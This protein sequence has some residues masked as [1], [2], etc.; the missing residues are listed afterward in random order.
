MS[1]D[2]TPNSQFPQIWHGTT[3]VPNTRCSGCPQSALA[4]HKSCVGFKGDTAH[5][6]SGSQRLSLRQLRKM[7]YDTFRKDRD[8]TWYYGSQE[9][10]LYNARDSF[11][12]ADS[13]SGTIVSASGNVITIE[14]GVDPRAIILF[15]S[16]RSAE[17]DIGLNFW[18]NGYG[19]FG[20]PQPGDGLEYGYPSI[21]QSKSKPT[22]K[23][24]LGVSGNQ[25]T[26]RID[27]NC[28]N[29]MTLV[30]D[31]IEDPIFTVRIWNDAGN[32]Q[33]WLFI[34]EPEYLRGEPKT[35][36]IQ[37]STL[38]VD[39][40]YQLSSKQVAHPHGFIP[41]I[42][43]VEGYNNA[44]HRWDVVDLGSR[45]FIR[46]FPDGAHDA[47]IS[48][49]TQKPSYAVNP[50]G[51]FSDLTLTYASFRVKYWEEADNDCELPCYAKCKHS[52]IDYTKSI[53]NYGAPDGVSVDANGVHRY[54]DKRRFFV[55][56]LHD[57]FDRISHY[58]EIVAGQDGIPDTVVY[59]KHSPSGI[60]NFPAN[61]KPC[62]QWLTCDQF[63]AAENDQGNDAPFRYA[64]HA[65]RFFR[66]LWGA[67]NT[68][69]I[70]FIPGIA[71]SWN[72]Q[73]Q[74][75][76]HAGLQWLAGIHL[77][78]PTGMHPRT[79]FV[80]V[81][82]WGTSVDTVTDD[83][84]NTRIRDKW[85]HNYDSITDA[86]TG[87]ITNPDGHFPA[88]VT[89]FKSSR[90]PVNPSG[91]V[92]HNEIERLGV[93][94][95]RDDGAI[96]HTRGLHAW[97]KLLPESQVI[98]PV[99]R[100]TLSGL[101][102]LSTSTFEKF[103]AALDLWGD[104]SFMAGA[105]IT[106]DPLRQDSKAIEG[107]GSRRIHSATISGNEVT[108]ELENEPHSWSYV[109]NDG[110]PFSSYDK[111]LTW[112]AGGASPF[113]PKDPQ[114]IDSYYESDKTIGSPDGGVQRGDSA[115]ISIE[116]FSDW[117]FVVTYA[118][119]FDGSE[120]P[121]WGDN[122]V[123]QHTY[124][125][126][127]YFKPDPANTLLDGTDT[128]PDGTV[129]YH[130]GE[131][132]APATGAFVALGATTFT[133]PGGTIRPASLSLNMFWHDSSTQRVYL[134][135]A[136]DGAT[137][138]IRYGVTGKTETYTQSY[139]VA[140]AP[141]E[142]TGLSYTDWTDAD[143]TAVTYAANGVP[144][145]SYTASNNSG[146]LALQLDGNDAGKRINVRVEKAGTADT[147]S[148][149]TLS[150]SGYPDYA[151]K[152]DVC[153]LIDESGLLAARVDTLAGQTIN[154]YYNG[155][156]YYP[157]GLAVEWTTYTV[158]AWTAL[159]STDYVST[160]GLGKIYIAQSFCATLPER[161][162]FRM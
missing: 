12:Y 112:Y 38:P 109:T 7:Q 59:E 83:E 72:F 133:T 15:A 161:V 82:T 88:D 107:A 103:T 2:L 148:E 81:G 53:G 55:P 80:G 52:R 26:L 139:T 155:A 160:H 131:M 154:F 158:D 48:F 49:G 125:V 149:F 100:T 8:A 79:E 37:A 24:V 17:S 70:Q 105:C 3:P 9:G 13:I 99:C 16:R 27:Q 138:T 108:I 150:S 47:V 106:I 129:I 89:G 60:A 121:T 134:S 128:L 23:Q 97:S 31:A 153:K 67:C 10:F 120:A 11:N 94:N 126:G 104:G 39:K 20:V 115:S 132:T 33:D 1:G 116:G 98:I 5:P 57:L 50:G 146:I 36:I 135:P 46:T 84:D 41:E 71:E 145:A 29:A 25:I 102:D 28:D 73:V 62:N 95:L 4:G 159:S 45:L 35:K 119:P 18:V 144:V 61:G 56:V 152:R 54:C 157:E 78:S 111:Q 58:P 44:A 127:G 136:N 74:R 63:E 6:P 86:E 51:T 151:K 101:Q 123:K 87:I 64:Y 130:H 21:L 118:K 43:S 68:R 143:T 96:S 14:L 156:V 137:V 22:I 75:I 162:C 76:K 91:T 90:D 69:V 110:T 42:F 77:K 122:I 34:Q 140:T 124:E 92:D 142:P 65:G 19:G 147:P 141:F 30:D 117:R 32:P 93:R 66:D 114:I 40:I 85:Q 113:Y